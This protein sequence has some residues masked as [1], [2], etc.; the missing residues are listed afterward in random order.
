MKKF[1]E[2]LLLNEIQLCFSK[3]GAEIKMGSD[4][5]YQLCP[6]LFIFPSPAVE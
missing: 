3:N 2:T 4:G 1:V 5:F 6:L